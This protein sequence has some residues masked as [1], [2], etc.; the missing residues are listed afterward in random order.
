MVTSAAARPSSQQQI[1]S[2][3]CNCSWFEPGEEARAGLHGQCALQGGDVEAIMREVS[4]I[5][6][7]APVSSHRSRRYWGFRTGRPGDGERQQ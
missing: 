6:A 5:A 3:C 2:M 1:S 4:S 7:V